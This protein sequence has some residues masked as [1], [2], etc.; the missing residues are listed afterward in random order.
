MVLTG[1][2]VRIYAN[3]LGKEDNRMGLIASKGI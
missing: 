2:N 3:V 1:K